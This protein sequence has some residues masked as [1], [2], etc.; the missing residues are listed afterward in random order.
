MV[1]L[2][3]QI[4]WDGHN[5]RRA[6]ALLTSTKWII[7]ECQE[8]NLER[9]HLVRPDSSNPSASNRYWQ[10]TKYFHRLFHT[11]AGNLRG[12]F[13]LHLTNKP[14]KTGR[15]WLWRS[16]YAVAGVITRETRVGVNFDRCKDYVTGKSWR[17]FNTDEDW[18]RGQGLISSFSIYY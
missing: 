11:P 18:S 2:R 6:G 17:D 12:K 16:Y 9:E 1:R 8:R 14:N 3:A 5:S 15:P 7:D 4:P 13:S 10:P